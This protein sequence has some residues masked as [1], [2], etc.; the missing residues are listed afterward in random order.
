LVAVEAEVVVDKDDSGVEEVV[1]VEVLREGC[2]Y[3]WRR[4][5]SRALEED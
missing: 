5:A 2:S 1:V 4:L 3:K